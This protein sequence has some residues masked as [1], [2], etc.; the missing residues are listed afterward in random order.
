MTGYPIPDAAAAKSLG[1]ALR[2]VGYSESG[3]HELLGE[4]AY[5]GGEE[6]AP[7]DERR[8]RRIRA[9]PRRCGLLERPQPDGVI[10]G[11]DPGQPH[12]AQS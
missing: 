6:D 1:F 10:R 3:V 4:D 11:D 2:A 8:R 5:S 7:A 12:L 9:G